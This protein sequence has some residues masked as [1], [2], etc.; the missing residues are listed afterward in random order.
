MR[1]DSRKSVTADGQPHRRAAARA[2]KRGGGRFRRLAA[3][4]LVAVAAS[5]F[6]APALAQTVTTLVS[7]T[8]QG[9]DDQVSSTSGRA[10]GFTTGSNTTGYTLHSIDI[11]SE[12]A[13]GDS[14]TATLYTANTSGYPGT[15]VATLAVPSSFVAGTLTFTAPAATTLLASTEYLVVVS[16]TAQVNF[17]TTRSD[18]EDSGAATGWSI[19]NAYAYDDNGTWKTTS[20][21]ESIRITVKGYAKTAAPN[22][23]PT[24]ATAIPDQSATAGT[25]FSYA[26]PDNTFSD[27]DSDTLTYTATKA[28]GTALPTWLS[29]TDSTRT[30][31]GTPQAADIATVSVKVTASD[32]NGGSVSDEFDITVSAAADTTPP[33][34]TSATVRVSGTNI[35][36]GFSES[37]LRSSPSVRPLPPPSRSLQAAVPSP[38]LA[39]ARYCWAT[40]SI[41]CYR[42]PSARARPSSSPTPT[43]PPATT[44]GPSRTW[45]ATTPR[46][47]PPA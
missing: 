43:P 14:F 15:S 46:P 24:V 44:P 33:T 47:S 5:A 7:N 36:F 27:A 1:D 20:S 39:P 38:S 42:L 17:D 40:G 32:G 12:D 22:T 9:D 25:A 21:R 4:L 30:F 35:N 29:F 18:A 45:P 23:A 37:L 16:L 3:A 31:S 19:A 13:A 34:L 28:D 11:V 2:A 26:F 10:Q 8:G 6:G 41:S